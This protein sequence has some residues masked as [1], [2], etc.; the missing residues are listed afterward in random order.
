ML[1]RC[2]MASHEATPCH[3]TDSPHTRRVIAATSP[4]GSNGVPS[5]PVRLGGGT[6]AH[7]HPC[8]AAQPK[9]G[10]ARRSNGV[11]IATPGPH[12]RWLQ[13]APSPRRAPAHPSP[14]GVVAT[15][16]RVRRVSGPMRACSTPGDSMRTRLCAAASTKCTSASRSKPRASDRALPELSAQGSTGLR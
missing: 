16:I 1:S 10:R 14:A 9:T 6:G 13:T 2:T 7:Y 15:D 3:R 4:S 12:T 5:R 11:Q 8:A